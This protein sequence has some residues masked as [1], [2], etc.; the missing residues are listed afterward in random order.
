MAPSGELAAHKFGTVRRLL[1]KYLFLTFEPV[2]DHVAVVKLDRSAVLAN[3][4]QH[5]DRRRGRRIS[6]LTRQRMN[7]HIALGAKASAYG[8]AR[9]MLA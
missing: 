5:I 4:H 6:A 8:T 2:R 3:D 9:N 7:V 1:H